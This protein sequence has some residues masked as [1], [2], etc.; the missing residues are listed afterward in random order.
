MERFE[1]AQVGD[2]VYCRR[3]GNGKI[4]KFIDDMENIFVSFEDSITSIYTISGKYM[5][6]D[7]EQ[8]L[9]Y[10][11]GSERYLTERPEQEIDWAK[12]VPGETFFVAEKEE[13]PYDDMKFAG[14]IA[15]GPVFSKDPETSVYYFKY[16]YIKRTLG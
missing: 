14:I 16:P 6:K 5:S 10:R 7:K 3:N 11:K 2:L 15:T 1:K 4:D 13:G 9:F 8:I 12:V